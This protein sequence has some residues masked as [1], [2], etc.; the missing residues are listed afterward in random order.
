MNALT[1]LPV[2]DPPRPKTRG[3]CKHGIR[4]CPW[5]SCR[6]HLYLDVS[7]RGR[8]KLNFGDKEPDELEHSCALDIAD[9]GEHSTKQLAR[10]IG[11]TKQGIEQAEWAALAKLAR[12]A[13]RKIL[14]R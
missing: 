2:I 5:V 4:P 9:K 1:R 6:F 7:S 14:D 3:D 13:R 11:K 10:M 8:L 12:P